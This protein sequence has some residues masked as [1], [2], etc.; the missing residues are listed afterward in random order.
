[1]PSFWTKQ[2]QSWNAGIKAGKA[3]KEEGL[4]RGV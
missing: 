1:M 2:T 4:L 3:G